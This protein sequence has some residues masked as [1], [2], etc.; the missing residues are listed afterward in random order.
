MKPVLVSGALSPAERGRA[1]E[2]LKSFDPNTPIVDSAAS[3][4]LRILARCELNRRKPDSV[5][6]LSFLCLSQMFDRHINPF[7]FE[8]HPIL[9]N[10]FLLDKRLSLVSLGATE[11]S[12]LSRMIQMMAGTIVDST[13]ADFVVA[14][15]RVRSRGVLV[16]TDWIDALFGSSKYIDFSKYELSA[17]RRAGLCNGPMVRS[18][19]PRQ[20]LRLTMENH[21]IMSFI[22]NNGSQETVKLGL[23]RKRRSPRNKFACVERNTKVDDYFRVASQVSQSHE[24][25]SA[26]NEE[27]DEITLPGEEPLSQMDTSQR[28]PRIPRECPSLETVVS[29]PV[30]GA[31]AIKPMEVRET[32]MVE[33]VK[34]PIL[35][36][37]KNERFVLESIDSDLESE[38]DEMTTSP[39]ADRLV[40]LCSSVMRHRGP[41]KRVQKPAENHVAVEELEGLSQRE[42]QD[43]QPVFDV[44]YDRECAI[45]STDDLDGKRDPLFDMFA[46]S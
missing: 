41:S 16:K 46:N 25:E 28:S 36:R 24:D 39:V 33:K 5:P 6:S 11:T 12:R 22:S 17:A 3:P 31:L 32:K 2:I 13:D 15:E 7:T 35:K 44:K 43:T 29:S 18:Q 37:E 10:L 27:I 30:R 34:K 9:I 40:H 4:R 19:Q 26:E 20:Q 21:S 45:V 14:R 42:E 23:S 8:G 1:I 38:D